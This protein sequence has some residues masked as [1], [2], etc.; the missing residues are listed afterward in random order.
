MLN[1]MLKNNNKL[2]KKCIYRLL[3]QAFLLS[4]LF[5]IHTN[6]F[7]KSKMTVQLILFE[8]LNF[9]YIIAQ[10]SIK[11]VFR[12]VFNFVLKAIVLSLKL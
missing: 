6:S 4:L 2:N 10:K 5:V 12:I 1:V 9:T 8:Y 11:R 3:Y 7:L